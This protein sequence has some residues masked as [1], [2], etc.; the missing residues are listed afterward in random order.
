MDTDDLEHERLWQNNFPKQVWF[1]FYNKRSI[2]DQY[3]GIYICAFGFCS[4][5]IFLFLYWNRD[6]VLLDFN[7]VTLDQL[8]MVNDLDSPFRLMMG[9]SKTRGLRRKC[10][11][12]EIVA[13][14]HVA[15]ARIFA[16]FFYLLTK[17]S[18]S[19]TDKV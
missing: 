4:H 2:W 9:W 16:D 7:S 13:E 6:I 18:T 1:K 15:I 17:R 12:W 8:G 14:R 10:R 19:E 3:I 5:R 11:K